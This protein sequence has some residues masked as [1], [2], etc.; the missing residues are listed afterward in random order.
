[1]FIGGLVGRYDGRI[2]D[3]AY[4]FA[5]GNISGFHFG[6]RFESVSVGGLVGLATNDDLALSNSYVRV[7]GSMSGY[8]SNTSF[9]AHMGGLM[10]RSSGTGFRL[11]NSYVVSERMVVNT[12]IVYG[13]VGSNGGASHNFILAN[14]Y[15]VS[16]ASR[17]DQFFTDRNSALYQRTRRQLECPTI[18]SENC[19]GAATYAGW[20][21]ETCLLY[22]SPSPRD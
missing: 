7:N 20:D 14:I 6:P 19:E 10:G 8:D 11:T 9:G 21:N 22:T 17:A 5:D 3:N 12:G 18:P 16:P 1:M 4:V 15:Y 13:F 2:I